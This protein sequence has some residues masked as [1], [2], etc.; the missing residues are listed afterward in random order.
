MVQKTGRALVVGAGI[1]GIRAALDLAETGHKVTLIDRAAHIGGI[2]SQLDYQFPTNRCGMC[3]MLPL[4][5]RDAA[6]Q[7]CLRKGLFHEN[8]EIL[9][10]TELT[11]VEGDAG[12]FKVMLRSKPNWVDPELCVGCGICTGV[13][14]VEVPDEFNAGLTLRKAIYLPVPHTV[15]IPY[16]IDMAACTRCGACEKVCPTEAIRLH[17]QERKKFHILVVDDELIVRNSLKDWLEDEGYDVNIA[18][19]GQEA[20]DLLKNGE[21]HLMLLDIKMPGMDGVEVLKKAKEAAPDLS[22]VMMT[23]YAT[24][25]TAVEA[26]KEGAIDYLMKPFDLEVL[27][28]MV[29]RVYEEFEASKTGP[30]EVGAIILCGGTSYFNPADEKDIFGYKSSGNIVTSLEFER[31]LSGTGPS[32]GK[33]TR[34]GDGREV[35]RAAWIQCVGSRNL[36]YDSDFCSSICCMHAI[37]E[38]MLAR[39]KSGNTIESSIYYMDM[40]TFGKSFQRY[41][42]AA[43]NEG[44]LLKRGRVHSIYEDEK[45]GDVLVRY[46]DKK[47]VIHEE[48]QDI[49]I[50]S[51]G[52]RPAPETKRIAEMTGIE[53]NQ[54]G[55][56][57]A[58]PFSL[59]RTGR[60]GIF[61]GGSFSGLKDI[62]ESVVQAGAASLSASISMGSGSGVSESAEPSE[63]GLRD[64]SREIPRIMVLIC[65][66]GGKFSKSIDSN[67]ITGRLKTD[68]EIGEVVFHEQACTE[69][70]LNNLIEIINEHKPNRLLIGACSPYL[71]FKKMKELG[72][73]VGLNPEL[74][75]IIDIRTEIFMRRNDSPDQSSTGRIISS[76][77]A[78]V[79]GLKRVD[80]SPVPEI[81]VSQKALVVGGG[82]AGMS[83]AL[84]VAAHGFE[85]YLVEMK[86]KTGGN[87][88][89]LQR[90]LDGLAVQPFSD[91]MR[92]KVETNPLIRV[93]TSSR[94]VWSNGRVGQFMTEI[95]NDKGE[96]K[97]I[98]HG[99]TIIATGGNEDKTVSYEYGKSNRILTQMELETKLAEKMIDPSGLNTV[100]MIQ[101][102]DS[103]DEKKNYCSR[104]C[105]VSALKHALYLKE[106]NPDISIYILYRDMMTYGFTEAF[107]TRARAAGVIFIQYDKAEKPEIKVKDNAIGVTVFE[108]VIGRYVIIEPDLLVLATGIVPNLPVEIADSLGASVDE[109]GFFR[110]AESKWRPVDSLK[111]GIFSC[112]IS[113]APYSIAESI[114]TAEAS[115]QRALRIISQNRL[116][117]GKVVAKVRRSLCSLCGQCIDACPYGAR[118]IEDDEVKVDVIMCQGCGACASACPNSAAIVDGY[119]MAR[120]LDVIDTVFI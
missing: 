66:C 35:R 38:A 102:V 71:F 20:L 48:P 53:L 110:E 1:S 106:Q 63:D 90:T 58:A 5:N 74:I 31:I 32:E 117:S 98:E 26:M 119:N 100:V 103:R 18:A 114:A 25:E 120:M 70:G 73:R 65:T 19:S 77:L 57:Q 39:E 34:P 99:V 115:A 4:V 84:A 55:F 108:P 86:E 44:V 75:D 93:H 23:A 101:C 62:G 30:L 112:G 54:W 46:S 88:A 24:V 109:N 116:R 69:S 56:A 11:A 59:T 87:L 94:V 2:L 22:V 6:V 68:P 8:I 91:D 14:P 82:I 17:E 97:L 7:R 45:S 105:C 92:K 37:K 41:L 27:I 21:Y 61:L 49:V 36:Q 85:V 64:V 9:L 67:E 3:K 96:K 81:N 40:R 13:C 80:P 95:E 16:L 60:D 10:S 12:N 83:A 43:G 42:D 89:W 118:M 50:L 72:R 104:I 79:A 76:I 28:P 107:Y 111:E 47:G 51:V 113:L 29:T 52:Q 78:G 33:I 15:P